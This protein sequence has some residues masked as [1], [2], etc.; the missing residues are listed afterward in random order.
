MTA[1]TKYNLTL[2]KIAFYTLQISKQKVIPFEGLLRTEL[3][4]KNN[5]HV[6]DGYPIRYL[7][8]LLPQWGTA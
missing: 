6:K 5:Q 8:R 4:L 7:F 3:H 2:Q 1:G